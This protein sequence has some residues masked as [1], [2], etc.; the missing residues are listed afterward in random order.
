MVREDGQVTVDMGAPIFEPSNIPFEASEYAPSYTLVVGE[1][2]L[3]IGAVS[4]GNPHSVN[5]VDDVAKLNIET[6]GPLVE[7]HSRFPERVNAGFM[8]IVSRNQVKLRVF[9]RG[10][11][12]TLACGSGACAAVAS[13]IQRGPAR[14]RG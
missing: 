5:I 9:E 12:E 14:Q 8:E 4:M 2:S 1:Q 7:S 13:G 3:E 11:G 6:I 10:V